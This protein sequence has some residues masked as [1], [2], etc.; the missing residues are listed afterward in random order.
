MK[1]TNEME[2]RFDSRSENEGFGGG[3]IYDPA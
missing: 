1:N 3:V 2:I